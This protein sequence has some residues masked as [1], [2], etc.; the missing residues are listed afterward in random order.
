M[1]V[2][3]VN[4]GNIE[5]RSGMCDPLRG[6]SSLPDRQEVPSS[7]QEL[8]NVLRAAFAL[9]PRPGFLL[10][11]SRVVSCNAAAIQML[12]RPTAGVE[13]DAIKKDVAVW[14]T[15]REKAV[16][17]AA[18][19]VWRPALVPRVRRK[20]YRTRVVFLE[21]QG[22]VHSRGFLSAAECRVVGALRRGLKTGEIA[23]ELGLSTDTVR[24]HVSHAMQ[25][26]G[27]HTRA[28]LVARTLRR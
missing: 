20:G 5:T 11:G 2:D 6:A 19:V 3:R 23:R 10:E 21:R 7:I 9:D 26:L 1:R 14:S 27:V 18:G 16:L 4:A 13:W 24:K 22:E 28:G 15:I 12:Q 8:L 25:R 17:H